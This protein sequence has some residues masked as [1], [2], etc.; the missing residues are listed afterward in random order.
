MTLCNIAIGK[1]LELSFGSSIMSM[2]GILV[3]YKKRGF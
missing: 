1:M 3:N 2:K